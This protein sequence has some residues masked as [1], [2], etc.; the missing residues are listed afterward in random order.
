MPFASPLTLG[1]RDDFARV[2]DYL[3]AAAYDAQTVCGRLSV[4]DL[5]A[6]D[7]L[8]RETIPLPPAADDPLAFLVRTFLL[9]QPLPEAALRAQ[10]ECPVGQPGPPPSCC[11]PSAISTSCPIATVARMG[12]R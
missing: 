4:P 12:H 5:F 1:D 8:P 7:D 3:R 11:I 6:V 10:P 9:L 2:A